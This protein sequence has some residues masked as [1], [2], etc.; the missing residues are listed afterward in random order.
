MVLHHKTETI[1]ETNRQ[2]NCQK[3]GSIQQPFNPES[4]FVNHSASTQ[5]KDES[6]KSLITHL[7]PVQSV[8]QGLSI[9]T[10]LCTHSQAIVGSRH[11]VSAALHSIL[12]S[13]VL[14]H[15]S[16]GLTHLSLAGHKGC[17]E[18]MG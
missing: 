2:G 12:V 10:G 15:S 16:L 11:P 14:L 7:Q 6:L 8:L 3:L 18:H 4:N 17:Q 9:T 13:L 1:T 5:V